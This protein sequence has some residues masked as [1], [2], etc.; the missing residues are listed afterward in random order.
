MYILVKAQKGKLKAITSMDDNTSSA[1]VLDIAKDMA[2]K[3]KN[4]TAIY[5]VCEVKHKVF[6]SISVETCKPI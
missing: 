4:D 5:Y 1:T 3:N 2:A 6:S